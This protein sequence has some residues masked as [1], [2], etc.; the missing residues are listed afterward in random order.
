[1]RS[2]WFKQCY[3]ADIL[4]GAK[5]DTIRAPKRAPPE[6]GSIVALSVGPVRPFATARV[7]DVSPIK[8]SALEPARR[9]E[10]RA[11][12][13]KAKVPLIRIQFELC[14]AGI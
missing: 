2:I 8:A 10:L 13:G 14:P 12:Y 1:M 5:R 9:A 3:V 4:S 11:L 7:I 6:V